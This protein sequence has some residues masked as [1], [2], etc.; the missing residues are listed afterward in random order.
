VV[1]LTVIEAMS[2]AVDVFSELVFSTKGLIVS[3]TIT[4][5]ASEKASYPMLRGKMAIM[6]PLLSKRA[7]IRTTLLS[8]VQG[9][10]MDVFQMGLEKFL[11]FER[12]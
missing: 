2:I 10:G 8:A 12:I 1:V 3:Y 6:V 4:S 9:I 11:C 7:S 5:W